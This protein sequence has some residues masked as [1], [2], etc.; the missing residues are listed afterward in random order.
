MTKTIWQ[1]PAVAQK[2][3]EETRGAIPYGPDQLRIML[4]LI[5]RFRPAARL[6]LDLG[7]G[8]GLLARTV[9]TAWPDAGALLL[10][11][12]EPMIERA[13]A[14]MADF[15][16]RCEIALADLSDSILP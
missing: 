11:H 5:E 12:S 16:G 7:C 8:D 10:D 9:L 1:E 14:R 15:E 2:Y 3:L 13:R 4:Q 6:V